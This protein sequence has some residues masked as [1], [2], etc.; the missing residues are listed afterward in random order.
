MLHNNRLSTSTE[1]RIDMQRLFSSAHVHPGSRRQ[2]AGI[3]ATSLVL[4]LL[5]AIASALATAAPASAAIPGLVRVETT[6]ALNSDP[7]SITANCPANT[8]VVGAGATLT[9]AS[10]EVILDDIAPQVGL[11]SVRASAYEEEDYTPNWTV[12]AIAMCAPNVPGLVR[13]ATTS[14][15]NSVDKT[16][17]AF[18]PTGRVLLGMGYQID[19]SGGSVLVESMH[20]INLNS[21]EVL[22]REEDAFT[23][24]WRLTTIAICANAAV[25]PVVVFTSS[26][27]S[28]ADKS[29][30]VP[31]PAGRNILGAGFNFVNAAGQVALDDLFQTTQRTAV[32]IAALEADPLANS[33]RIDAWAICATP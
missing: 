24:E 19:G 8:L 28:S 27:T 9:G 12:T 14:P 10:G 5:V 29:M 6:S 20:P 7:K 2:F 25:A 23:G 11:L 3:R 31:C 32:N 22:A 21:V 26:G 15:Y 13:V 16:L 1:R 30:S 4:S 33:W 18:C 17:I